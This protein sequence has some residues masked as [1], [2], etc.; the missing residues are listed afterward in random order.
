MYQIFQ[1]K[2]IWR[3]WHIFLDR[4][5]I[6]NVSQFPIGSENN[7]K[8]RKMVATLGLFLVVQIFGSKG[9]IFK[10]YAKNTWNDGNMIIHSSNKSTC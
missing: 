2:L 8:Q 9:Q 7:Y 6:Q 1:D 10:Q 5:S 4:R 3:I